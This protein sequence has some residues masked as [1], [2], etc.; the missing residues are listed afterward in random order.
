ML[1]RPLKLDDAYL[2]ITAETDALSRNSIHVTLHPQ[3]KTV[4]TMAALP[5]STSIATVSISEIEVMHSLGPWTSV[6]EPLSSFEE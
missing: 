1:D 5:E 6:L 2:L 4:A 3:D